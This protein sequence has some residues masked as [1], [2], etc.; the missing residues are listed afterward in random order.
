MANAPQLPRT[1][2]APDGHRTAERRSLAMHTLV[3]EQLDA[4]R[5]D[6]ARARVDQWLHD[7]GPVDGHWASAWQALLAHDVAYVAEAIALDDPV[8]TQLR[9]TTPFAGAISSADRHRIL[10]EVR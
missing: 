7:G 5:L 2:P 3:A 8:M 10:R 4:A 9:Q 6:Q 1:W